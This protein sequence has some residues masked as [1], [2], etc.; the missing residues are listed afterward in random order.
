MDKKVSQLPPK[1]TLTGGEVI[2]I[3]DVNDLSDSPQGTDKKFLLVNNN[4]KFIEKEEKIEE[5]SIG[6]GI[7]THAITNKKGSVLIGTGVT[8]INGCTISSVLNYYDGKKYFFKNNTSLNVTLKNNFAV[9]IPFVFPNAIDFTLKPNETI[10]FLLRQRATL[11]MEF[12]GV[13]NLA[14]GGVERQGLHFYASA[15]TTTFTAN[16]F[17][18]HISRFTSGSIFGSFGLTF[19]N[20]V[21][22]TSGVIG[23]D[24]LGDV[25]VPLI[26]PYD[27]TIE[28]VII[29]YS[30][31]NTES[32]DPTNLMFR[33]MSDTRYNVN[34]Q[35]VCDFNVIGNS[36][37]GFS[38]VSIP[39]TVLTHATI[40]KGSG[41]KFCV[42]TN[43][44]VS[45]SFN[46]I[47]IIVIV[48]KL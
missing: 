30:K 6:T 9:S 7:I 3:L 44:A 39:V 1:N 21:P 8:Q 23:M 12:V 35:M 22:E 34:N 5:F 16:Q 43:N 48:K 33:M 42:R 20:G 26:V 31:S 10:E 13:I 2:H 24:Y 4:E 45:Q 17:N 15:T 25:G 40:A 38:E 29:R 14:A 11:V 36:A 18:M 46:F 19:G 27:C 28:E 47:R 32:S 37:V 41:L